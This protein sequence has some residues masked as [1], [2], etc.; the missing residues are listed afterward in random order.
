MG[1]ILKTDQMP[2]EMRK[3]FLKVFSRM[4]QRVIWKWNSGHMDN[5]PSNVKLSKWLPQQ[6]ILGHPNIKLF[7][8]HGGLLSTQEAAYHGVP[9]LGI[10]MFGDQDLNVK[11]AANHVY[12]VMLEILDLTEELLEDRLNTILNDP[13]FTLKAKHLSSIIK[14]QPQTPLDRAVF[15]TEY[16]IRHKGA[17]H[18]RSAARKLNFFQYHSLDVYAFVLAILITLIA[19]SVVLCK[20]CIRKVCGKKGK[21][22]SDKK[23]K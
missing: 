20:V 12:A 2:E 9:V 4:K 21:V 11:Q 8:S 13:R 7:I 14:D 1:S 22:T 19:A 17:P 10:P 16:L 5:L 6:D 15:W 23:Q 18:L 3:T